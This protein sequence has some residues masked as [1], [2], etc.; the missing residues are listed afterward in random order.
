[1]ESYSLTDAMPNNTL[2]AFRVVL[3][4]RVQGVGFRAFTRRNAMLLGLRG[5]IANQSDGTVKAHIEGN[6]DRLSQMLHLLQVGPSLARVEDIDIDPVEPSGRYR[7]FE[8][9]LAH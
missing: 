6:S 8:V 5:E 1:M 2:K 9:S 7:T 4:G 3:R